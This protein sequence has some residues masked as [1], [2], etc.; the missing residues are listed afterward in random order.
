MKPMR[1]VRTGLVLVLI[2]ASQHIHGPD[3]R[4]TTL[5]WDGTGTTWNGTGP[6]STSPSA[7]T[8]DPAAKP[9][10]GD[11][12][13]FNITSVNSL[14]AVNL[15]AAQSAL[16]L[17]FA[18]TGTVNIQSGSG[19]N[20]LTIGTSGITVNAGAGADTISAAVSLSGQ[21]TWA[22]SPSNT[23]TVSGNIANG[24]NLLIAT[25]TGNTTLNGAISGSGGLTWNGAGTLTLSGSSA[26]AYSG[27]TTVNSGLVILNKPVTNGTIVGSTLQINGGTVREDAN[28]QIGD[29]T[30][31]DIKA[32]GLLQLASGVTDYWPATTFTGGSI[33][34]AGAGYFISDGIT[35]NASSTTATITGQMGINNVLNS[36][37]VTAGTTASGI[38]LD[39]PATILFGSAG[40][41]V[42]SGSG[43]V[44]LSGANTYSG[45][46]TLNAGTLLIGNNAALGTGAL[47]VNGGTMQSDGAAHSVSNAVSL[48]G[49]LTVSGTQDLIISGVV[50]GPAGLTK[51]GAGALWLSGANTF[52]AGTIFNSGSLLIADNSALGS[53]TLAMSNNTTIQTVIGDHTIANT[54]SMTAGAIGIVDGFQ[55]LT[56][57]G[58]I[59]G[60][61]LTKNGTGTL[62][63]GGGFLGSNAFPSGVTVNN[64]TVLLNRTG[65]IFGNYA[66]AIS[67]PSLQ[68]GNAVNPATVRFTGQDDEISSSTA[69]TIDALAT[70]D[71]NGFQYHAGS[72]SFFNGGTLTTGV[73]GNLHLNGSVTYFGSTGSTATISGF[74]DLNGTETFQ[75]G[76]GSAVIDLDVPAVLDFGSI[77]KNASGTLR[78]SGANTFAGGVTI[79]GGTLLLGSAGA[80]NS[81]SPNAVSFG[82]GSLGILSLNGNSV[83]V[84]G[85]NTNASVGTPVVQNANGASATLTVNNAVSNE[86]DGVLQDGNGGGFLLLTKT[87]AGTLT[88]GGNNLYN[89]T[90]TINA[91]TLRA[92][93]GTALGSTNG[94]TTVAA[95]ATLDI[96][97]FVGA[98]PVSIQGTGVGGAGALTGSSASLAGAVNLTGPATIGVPAGAPLDLLGTVSGNFALTKVGVGTLYFYG[99]NTFAGGLIINAGNVS[100]GSAGALN[101]TNSVTFGTGS[102]ESLTLNGN[103]VTIGGLNANAGG[104]PLIQNISFTP[105]TLTVNTAGSDAY[106][107]VLQDGGGAAA[108]S[109]TKTGAGTLTLSGANTFTGNLAINGGTLTMSGG[110]LAANVVNSAT[111]I[112]NSGTFNGRLTNAGVVTF[113]AD[114][115]AGN[116]LENDVNLTISTGRIITLGGLGLD[117][118]GTL[119]MAG[120]GLNLSTSGG[121]S[122]VNRGTFNLNSMLPFN[123]GGATLN[124]SGILNLDGGL[125]TGSM[126]SLV[127]GIGGTVSGTGIITSP[128]TNSGVLTVGSGMINIT[129][130]FAN[131]GL[132][133]L[134]SVDSD[135]TGGSITN[136]ATIQ[137]LGIV[138]SPVI[139]STG[140]IRAS[141]GELDLG[142]A[143]NTNAAGA[144]IQSSLGNT[145]LYVQGLA[146]SAGTI[147]LSGGAFD[148]NNRP[149]ANTGI[150]NGRGDVRTGGLTSTGSIN[151]GGG[152][153]NIFGPVTNNGTVNVQSTRTIYFFGNV[154]GP[155]SYTGTGTVVYLAGFSPGSSPA[156]VN[157]AGN[158]TL[159]SSATLNMELGG[160]IPGAEFDQAHVA[161]QLALDGALNVSLINGFSPT[162]GNT[163][164]ILDWGT[165]I[166]TFST[167]VLPALAGGLSWDTSQFYTNGVLS[168]VAPGLAGDYNKN[169]IVDAADYVVWRK[170]LGQT[171]AGLAA[172]GNAN[173]QI[174]Q[175]DFD[176]WRAHFGQ[177][178]GSGSGATAGLS[179]SASGA[180]GSA[181]AVPEPSG[182]MLLF[183]AT[184]FCALR[185]RRR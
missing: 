98:E 180:T 111:F 42:K 46:W 179:S 184:S 55:N 112:Y 17:T 4:A 12:A 118:E 87:G 3:S 107:G 96:S 143:G 147:A 88:L 73:G 31:V 131:T 136:T 150:I 65:G 56:L 132:I 116:G 54:I 76:H 22:N 114:F 37:N 51:N 97:A 78:L 63:L 100:V 91:G 154:N 38:D 64:G 156:S 126:S 169:G 39:V 29:G 120:G 142:G 82:A 32:S 127:N 149:L 181:S 123:L 171:G 170:T 49:G 70:L 110:S 11:I 172:D 75:I 90:T 109:L 41:I 99:N 119:T 86:Y 183:L 28:H 25:G 101:S 72:L 129:Q 16:G 106:N 163:F 77:I 83:T 140:I 161:G 61:G 105:A 35:T 174:D 95:G 6:W 92:T 94:G 159:A 165:L 10:A 60:G 13:N 93:S 50:S 144:Q 19:T 26:N 85:L 8:P 158:L 33:L 69:V 166:G 151:V 79:N 67:G 40:T 5:Y 15:D 9:G 115:T 103:S 45:A 58:I 89:G 141:G 146:T 134:T 153:M 135:L 137:G 148:N 20:T 128:F 133:H 138:N 122:N 130:P 14:Q 66:A 30:P 102:V 23:F 80:L 177:T 176:I 185:H 36:W 47:T 24:G 53:G 59:S 68:I 71:L 52:S 167:L 48:A 113:N 178:A 84:S 43:T 18:S 164:D 117:N 160:T 62:T 155:G 27:A 139:N 57:N 34:T 125:V 2:V 7:T 145:V 21:Q 162:I 124:N 121:A 173:N 108:L 168:I 152:D 44:R 1:L 157:F 74:V 175:G 81:G 182:I 104:N